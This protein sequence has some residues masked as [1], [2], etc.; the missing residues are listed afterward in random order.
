MLKKEKF[1]PNSPITISFDYE[2]NGVK[3]HRVV[4]LESSRL[5]KSAEGKFYFRGETLSV[6]GQPPKHPYST[7]SDEFVSNVEAVEC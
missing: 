3:T 2:K 4:K 1:A 5:E 6:D 7:Y